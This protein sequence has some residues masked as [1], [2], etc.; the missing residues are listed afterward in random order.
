MRCLI[1]EVRK[2]RRWASW[3]LNKSWLGSADRQNNFRPDPSIPAGWFKA[4]PTWY[5]GSGYDLGH[6]VP[7]ADR[8]KTV[9]DNSSTFLMTNM[10]PQTPDNKRNTGEL[11]SQGK[12][13]FII[14]GPF[15]SQK[16]PLKGKVVIPASTPES[17]CCAR[18]SW[19]WY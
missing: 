9:E 4:T 19:F 11:V 12:E 17:Y 5:A 8:T 16:Q 1:T 6:V 15:G 3:Q 7:S 10:M 18:P 2:F 13:L 14:A